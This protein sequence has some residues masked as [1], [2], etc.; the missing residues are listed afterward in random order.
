MTAHDRQDDNYAIS[1][2]QSQVLV[3]LLDRGS[4]DLLF[5]SHACASSSSPNCHTDRAKN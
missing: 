3:L 5:S 1:N 4:H 2:R